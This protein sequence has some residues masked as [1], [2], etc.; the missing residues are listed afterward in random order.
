MSK[1]SGTSLLS[2]SESWS[3]NEDD[4][5]TLESTVESSKDYNPD[6]KVE[7]EEVKKILNEFIKELPEKEGKVLHL[8]YYKS[9]TLKEIGKVLKVTESRVSQLHTKAISRLKPKLSNYK[10][11]II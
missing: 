10:K 1:I 9:L 5:S 3:N 6:S 11:G 8:Y 4:K 7:E 2:L